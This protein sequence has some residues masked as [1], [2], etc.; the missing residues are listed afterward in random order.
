MTIKKYPG[1]RKI[2]HVSLW[3]ALCDCCKVDSQ[4]PDSGN[5]Y[6]VFGTKD[7]VSGEQGQVTIAICQFC[8]V[9]KAALRIVNIEQTLVN[10]PPL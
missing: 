8:D 7:L 5:F 6:S 10:D 4:E 3:C 9:S 1:K 2:G